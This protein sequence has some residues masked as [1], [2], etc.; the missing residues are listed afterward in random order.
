MFAVNSEG[1]WG[2]CHHHMTVY[3]LIIHRSPDRITQNRNRQ[4]GAVP[5]VDLQVCETDGALWNFD[6]DNV[7]IFLAGYAAIRIH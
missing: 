4:G 6:S 5:L 2:L 1:G 3:E 7:P